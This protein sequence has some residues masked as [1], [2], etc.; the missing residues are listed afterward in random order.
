MGDKN[1]VIMLIDAEKAFDKNL[2]PIYDKNS[3]KR[4]TRGSMS[5]HNKSTYEKPTAN[6]ILN[7]EKLKAFSLR[8]ITRQG[9]PLLS[10]LLNV[11]LEVP[12]AA[13]R[14]EKEIKAS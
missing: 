10:F 6:T 12:I 2:A 14:Q 8:C 9:C 4:G 3:E 11:V 1:H 7:G 13:I 5:Q